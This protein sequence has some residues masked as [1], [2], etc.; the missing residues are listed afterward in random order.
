MVPN[1]RLRLDELVLGPAKLLSLPAIVLRMRGGMADVRQALKALLA[2]NRP[3]GNS[4]GWIARLA[5]AGLSKEELATEV[6]HLYGAFNAIDFVVTGAL[7]ELARRAEIR[8]NIRAELESVLGSRQD[9][10]REDHHKLRWTN[11]FMLEIMRCY[12]V[13]MGVV[14]SSGGPTRSCSRSCGAIR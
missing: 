10:A 8:T 6:N 1:P 4:P 9:L 11:A 3:R 5:D 2:G 13:T 14:R 7:Y 12:P